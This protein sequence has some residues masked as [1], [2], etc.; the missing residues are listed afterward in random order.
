MDDEDDS[1]DDN[2]DDI[3]EDN[4]PAFDRPATADLRCFTKL[5]G[6]SATW[7]MLWPEVYEQPHTY[8]TE[9][10]LDPS[11]VLSQTAF[12]VRT[13]LPPSLEMLYVEGQFNAWYWNTLVEPFTRL[14]E[15][16]PLL[17]KDRIRIDGN[18]HGSQTGEILG[19]L[20][21][22]SPY[23]LPGERRKFGNAERS[24]FEGAEPPMRLF[25]GHGW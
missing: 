21:E 9:D 11:D 12:D 5:R 15:Q 6:L 8:D 2:E 16:T 17:T 10:Y 1:E 7:M 14:S 19:E 4:M 23:G 20:D 13:V 3:K 25:D 22:P 18:L 24:W